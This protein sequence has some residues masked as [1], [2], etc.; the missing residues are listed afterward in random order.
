[1]SSTYKHIM[2]MTDAEFENHVDDSIIDKLLDKKE[3]FCRNFALI[4]NFAGWRWCGSEF[5]PSHD[6]ITSTY[7]SM[8]Y[9]IIKSASKLANKNTDWHTEIMQGRIC[10][11]VSYFL[12]THSLSVDVTAEI[13]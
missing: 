6:E 8:M 2:D 9:T 7:T 11:S 1:M 13:D 4:A 3:V 5:A 10:M 12:N